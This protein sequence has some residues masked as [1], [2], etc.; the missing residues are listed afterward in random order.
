MC[1]RLTW[2]QRGYFHV[3]GTA[4]FC[5]F[6]QV[7]FLP[8]P[9]VCDSNNWRQQGV[10]K[11]IKKEPSFVNKI[12]LCALC[13]KYKR[14]KL[15]FIQFKV[16]FLTLIPEDPKVLKAILPRMWAPEWSQPGLECWIRL[17]RTKLAQAPLGEQPCTETTA[18]SFHNSLSWR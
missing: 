16:L 2:V 6:T 15:S 5:A 9:T 1:W 14:T 8:H 13:W 10:G 7:A 4:S 12:S 3:F 18:P 17:L 11:T